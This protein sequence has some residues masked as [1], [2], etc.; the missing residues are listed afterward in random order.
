MFEQPPALLYTV[1]AGL[2]LVVFRRIIKHYFENRWSRLFLLLPLTH[3]TPCLPLRSLVIFHTSLFILC[4]PPSFNNWFG[5]AY[6]TLASGL[7]A[8]WTGTLI[9]AVVEITISSISSNTGDLKRVGT[10]CF[11]V[12]IPWLVSVKLNYVS[13]ALGHFNNDIWRGSCGS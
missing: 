4:P 13:I 10:Y 8:G 2:V 9:K 7:I 3:P 12:L 11:A 6:L 1:L 5:L